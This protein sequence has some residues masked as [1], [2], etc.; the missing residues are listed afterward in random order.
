VEEAEEMIS[1][2]SNGSLKTENEVE[3]PSVG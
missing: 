3:I 2:A 1:S